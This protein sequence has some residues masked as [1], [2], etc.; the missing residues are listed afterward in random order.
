MI[1]EKGKMKILFITNVPSPYRV[2]FFNELGKYCDLTVLFEKN[3]SDERD[4]SWKNYTFKN[5]KGIILNGKKLSTD[6]AFCPEILKYVT[7][8]SFDKVICTTF[9]DLTGMLA[10]QTMKILG[11]PYYLECDGG[12]AKSGRGFREKIKKR[13]I[14]GARG[15]FSTGISCD[16]YYLMYGAEKNR[17][18]RYP[19]SSIFNIDIHNE[20]M[21]EE[22]KK[23]LKNELGI[24][25]ERL[26]LTVGQFIHRKG[27]DVLLEAAKKLPSD[28]GIYFV[29]GRP[30]K[31]YLEL[32]N[33]LT[34]VHFEGYKQKDELAKYYK[35]AD[36]FVLPTREDI[37]GLV[38]QEA[39]AYGLPI[40][41]TDK[42]AAALEVVKENENGYIV[43]VE[44]SYAI[45]KRIEDIFKSKRKI[46]EFRNKSHEII[47][48]Y[49]IE[50]MVECHLKYFKEGD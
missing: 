41:S 27:F 10:I 18:M 50:K 30:T 49:T 22:E 29:G 7:N 4:E 42:C 44:D 39:M 28:I 25:E 47:K 3:T 14:T 2:D 6:T 33:G 34:N 11:I 23:Y 37:W 48:S 24:K 19:F 31:E 1:K 17:L 12:F 38:I 9:T 26:I 16:E 15:Y 8:R 45:E 13:M 32:Q 21:N 36:I 40:I 20:I 35:V 5:F 46:Q 43:P